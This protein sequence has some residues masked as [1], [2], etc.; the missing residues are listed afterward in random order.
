MYN[1]AGIFAIINGRIRPNKKKL[2]IAF[3]SE[4]KIHYSET[5]GSQQAIDLA[6]S[7]QAG[8]IIA[9]GGDGTIHEV[10]NGIDLEKQSVLIVPAGSLNCLA[11]SL[12]INS[13]E[14][15]LSLLKNKNKMEKVDLI[16]SRI[17]D[18][19]GIV[20]NRRIIGF[21][22][23]GFD[24]LVAQIAG[25]LR[26]VYAPL[27]YV[28]S[29]WG[30]IAFVKTAKANICIN[31][32]TMVIK[33]SFTSF[34]VNNGTANAF[35]AIKSWDMLDGT[36]EVQII[37]LPAILHFFWAMLC[38]S[39]FSYTPMKCVSRLDSTWDLPL[40]MMADG[41]L[42]ENVISFSMKVRSN[43]L[44]LILPVNTKVKR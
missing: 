39:P 4:N 44:Q 23:V 22:S 35:S 31:E 14:S 9:V 21:A 25:K 36:G 28:L 5:T 42:F 19:D 30:A 1:S 16:D 33:K 24:G 27:R 15:A 34:L 6:R 3:F 20:Y 10:V 41:E 26:W 8:I 13:I 11:R 17:T 38:L 7:S 40:P 29:G 18:V 32:S 37:R 2:I 12:G 43:T